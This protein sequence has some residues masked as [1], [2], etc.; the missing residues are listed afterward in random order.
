MAW[1]SNQSIVNAQL[2]STNKIVSLL[3]FIFSDAAFLL[4]A[5]MILFSKLSLLKNIKDN[6]ILNLLSFIFFLFMVVQYISAGGKGAIMQISMVLILIPFAL[7]VSY[8]DT[9]IAIPKIKYIYFFILLA[10]LLYYIV[11][12]QRISLGSN[13][14]PDLGTLLNSLALFKFDD[15]SGIFNNI[16]YR[17]TSGGLDR[18][19]LVFHSFV[20]DSYNFNTTLDFILYIS[21]NTLNL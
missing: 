10:P 12:I 3:P 21:K 16:L 14:E 4:L 19:L 8:K 18:F 7:L 11:S 13:I 5:G 1:Q 9:K 17:L 20:F 2:E 15:I 6:N